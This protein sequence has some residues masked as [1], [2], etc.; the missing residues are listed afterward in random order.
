MRRYPDKTVHNMRRE[1]IEICDSVPPRS[2]GTSA[3]PIAKTCKKFGQ[4]VPHGLPAAEINDFYNRCKKQIRKIN[5][6]D[7]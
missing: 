4:T 7:S 1:L 3:C 5:K 2:C 6:S